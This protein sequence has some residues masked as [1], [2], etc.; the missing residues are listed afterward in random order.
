MRPPRNPEREHDFVMRV[1]PESA[2][3]QF[4]VEAMRTNTATMEGLR[5]EAR[6][7][8]KLL[9]DIHTR[10]VRIE[11]QNVPGLVQ[12][13]DD[14]ESVKDKEHGARSLGNWLLDKSPS[15][16]AILV[17]IFAAIIATLKV[18]GRI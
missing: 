10:V 12:K 6:E 15:I 18:T 3:M 2:A 13:I 11:A 5:A 7:D 9:H 16:A 8:R 1:P 4:F 17:A 14:L